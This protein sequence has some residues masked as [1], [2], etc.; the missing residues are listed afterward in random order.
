MYL[1]FPLFQ[2]RLGEGGG[3]G[4]GGGGGDPRDKYFYGGGA[5]PGGVREGRWGGD[6]WAEVW[7]VGGGA[8][9]GGGVGS[10]GGEK[11]RR[12]G[13]GI[14]KGGRKGEARI[15]PFPHCRPPIEFSYGLDWEVGLGF[16]GGR[17]VGFGTE[18][19][20]GREMKPKKGS[21]CTEGRE[22]ATERMAG[23]G[24]W[25]PVFYLGGVGRPTSAF[26]WVRRM[27]VGE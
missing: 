14:G 25:I 26:E 21:L 8:G 17:I 9:G 27:L 20:C 24:R 18:R 4:G 7:A 5:A 22:K 11:E 3:G 15:A 23:K 13:G 2:K 12:G 16:Q 19:T 10:G 1:H 6:G